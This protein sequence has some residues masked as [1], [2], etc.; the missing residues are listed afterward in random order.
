ML[1]FASEAHRLHN[2]TEPHLFA[3]VAQPPR[4]NAARA[5]AILSALRAAGGHQIREPKP[6]D[7]LLIARV[8]DTAY[9]EFLETAH[10]RWCA[11]V[12]NDGSGEALPFVRP[13]LD[14]G[15]TVPDHIL[16]QLGRYSNDADPILA[17]TWE[18]V[19]SGAACAVSAA[20]AVVD[21]GARAAYAMARPPGH[22]AGPDTFGG[23]CYLNNVAIAAESVVR[24]GG[25]VATLDVDTHA[26]NGTQ[27]IFW[28][29][30]DVM[31]V[32]LHV[33][34]AVEYPYYQGY[35]HER[36]AAQGEGFNHNF[37]MP[38]GT[39]W[40]RYEPVLDTACQRVADFGPDVLIVALGT[41]TATED[42][43]MSLAGDDYLRLG[44]HLARIGL[45]TVLIQEGGYDLTVLGRN[46]AAV[47][48][49]FDQTA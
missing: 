42:G 8:H 46:L 30:D 16:A 10:V 47:L 40:A 49:G 6:V 14:A 48:H 1:V 22:H 35:A 21:G 45:P 44:A 34:P 29:R 20:L 11:L 43:V 17:G 32:S 19:N 28:E 2:P 23:Y 13:M 24:R 31:T 3:G 41:D 18:A 33:D 15:F 12:G 37:P 36:G 27:T 39:E 26:G 5:D 25:R 4:E 9:L 38:L 7:P